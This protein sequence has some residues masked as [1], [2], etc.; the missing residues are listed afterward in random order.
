MA[1]INIIIPLQWFWVCHWLKHCHMTNH[2]NAYSLPRDYRPVYSHLWWTID[3]SIVLPRPLPRPLPPGLIG[4]L[5]ND[6]LQVPWLFLSKIIRF[7]WLKRQYIC[8]K[9]FLIQWNGCFGSISSNND[10]TTP[11]KRHRKWFSEQKIENFSVKKRIIFHWVW[12]PYK[13]F[14]QHYYSNY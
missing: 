5:S 13:Q 8:K 6:P 11:A 7:W 9:I 3:G 1:R 14:S 4:T 2:R 12:K 10:A